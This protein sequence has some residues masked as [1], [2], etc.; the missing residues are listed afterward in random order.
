MYMCRTENN[1]SWNISDFVLIETPDMKSDHAANLDVYQI[2]LFD[3]QMIY[4]MDV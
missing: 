1:I 3:K 2:Y 4:Q